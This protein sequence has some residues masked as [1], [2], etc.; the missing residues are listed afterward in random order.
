MGNASEVNRINVE[1]CIA[2]EPVY[3]DH[4]SNIA[5]PEVDPIGSGVI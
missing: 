4:C 3:P 1:P 2:V 5:G